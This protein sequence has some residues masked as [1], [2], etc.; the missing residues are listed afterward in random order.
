[1]KFGMK[2]FTQFSISALAAL[3]LAGCG[4]HL[5]GSDEAPPILSVNYDYSITVKTSVSEFR[6]RLAAALTRREFNLVEQDGDY[7]V[8]VFDE[9]YNEDDFALIDETMG[10]NLRTLYY[11]VKFRL[12]KT[13]QDGTVVS[14]T[15]AFAN[16][17]SRIGDQ[18]ISRDTTTRLALQRTRRQAAELL[19]DR[20]VVLI[21][22]M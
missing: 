22:D 20:L 1:M 13:G 12:T 4:F 5:R 8:E 15:I 11:S 14:Q 16:D 18:E 21:Q 3:M 17:Y 9:Q 19:A 2:S 10:L 6:V 7:Q